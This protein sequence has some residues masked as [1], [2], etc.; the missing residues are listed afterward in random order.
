ML[1][2]ALIAERPGDIPAGAARTRDITHRDR[3]ADGE[4]GGWM[5][6]RSCFVGVWVSR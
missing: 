4:I 5:S 6:E 1:G 2:S 3:P